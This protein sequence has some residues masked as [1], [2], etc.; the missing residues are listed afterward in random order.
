MKD[1]CF[2]PPWKFLISKSSNSPELETFKTRSTEI[3]ISVLLNSNELK[4]L[5]AKNFLSHKLLKEKQEVRDRNV[6][7]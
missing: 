5:K 2:S 1:F 3:K 4:I 6:Y 7:K